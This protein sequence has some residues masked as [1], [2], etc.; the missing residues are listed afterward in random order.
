MALPPRATGHPARAR[1]RQQGF[2]ARD[3]PR[4]ATRPTYQRT[5]RRA[6]HPSTIHRQARFEYSLEQRGLTGGAGGAGGAGAACASSGGVHLSGGDSVRPLRT[7]RPR[8]GRCFL[9]AVRYGDLNNLDAWCVLGRLESGRPL[10]L[11][12]SGTAW[13]TSK[14]YLWSGLSLERLGGGL[15]MSAAFHP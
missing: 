14:I 13:E 12:V 9:S 8:G 15:R 7:P 3:R 6:S 2:A 5:S 1:R 11:G 4:A 10:K